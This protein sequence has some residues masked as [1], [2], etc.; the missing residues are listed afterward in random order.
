MRTFHPC[1]IGKLEKI[2]YIDKGSSF[3]MKYQMLTCWWSFWHRHT[4]IRQACLNILC[5]G[6]ISRCSPHIHWCLDFEITRNKDDLWLNLSEIRQ[7]TS[8]IACVIMIVWSPTN[9]LF[10]FLF[11]FE[12]IWANA[13]RCNRENVQAFI[14]T[15]RIIANLCV[16]FASN[17]GTF[18]LVDVVAFASLVIFHIARWA[19]SVKEGKKQHFKSNRAAIEDYTEMQRNRSKFTDWLN[20]MRSP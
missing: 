18:T 2:H 15:G 7:N 20:L 14:T 3:H 12:S 16:H 1:R 10:N 11:K 6:H 4:R 17:I 13:G 9:A 5:S 8:K 19:I